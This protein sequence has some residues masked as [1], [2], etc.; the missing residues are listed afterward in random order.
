MALGKIVG[1]AAHHRRHAM[2]EG[3]REERFQWKAAPR[4]GVS[5]IMQVPKAALPMDILVDVHAL[6]TEL[7]GSIEE[8]K[9][10]SAQLEEHIKDPNTSDA[11]KRDIDIIAEKVREVDQGFQECLNGSGDMRQKC[12]TATSLIPELRDEIKELFD[13]AKFD[14]VQSRAARMKAL[15]EKK[16]VVS[17]FLERTSRQLEKAE[18][19]ELLQLLKQ[20]A[21]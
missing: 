21:R 7:K 18:A 2:A 6:S 17:Q 15:G 13:T 4:G 3:R 20:L 16:G 12:H 11:V 9:A 5:R 10:M 19:S 8:I 1:A 14:T